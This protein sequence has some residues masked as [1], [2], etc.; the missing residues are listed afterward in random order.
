[1]KSGARLAISQHA[2]AAALQ[3][4]DGPNMRNVNAVL[5]KRRRIAMHSVDSLTDIRCAPA[6]G[7]F[8]L[9]LNIE[10]KLGKSYRGGT[11]DNVGTLCELML[12]EADVAVVPGDA[13]GDPTGLRV[14]YAIGT[15][16]VEE[17][18]L[19]MKRVPAEIA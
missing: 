7:A 5:E 14:S 19:R 4:E 8:H 13:R 11:I 12:R 6:E 18:L 10:R 15:R 3:H 1:M 16:Q 9:F 2:A 17:G